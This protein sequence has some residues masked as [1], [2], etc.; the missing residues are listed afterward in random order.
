MADNLMVDRWNVID[1]AAMAVG[2]EGLLSRVLHNKPRPFDF[3]EAL[4]RGIEFLREAS[5]G[6]AIIC[7]NPPNNGFTGTLSPLCW[8][9]DAYIEIRPNQNQAT[10]VYP[11]IVKALKSYEE[12]LNK[13]RSGQA[14]S[15]AEAQSALDFFHALAEILS[16][17]ADPATK[18]YSHEICEIS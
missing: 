15:K 7:G 17:Q 4:I 12:L 6:G 18:R 13:L 11:E 16:E 10:N 14:Y 9:T 2:V 1:A 3:D 5:T 8:S